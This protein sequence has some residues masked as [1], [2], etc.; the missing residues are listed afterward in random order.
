MNCPIVE[1]FPT[2]LG[3]VPLDFFS[4]KETSAFMG[5]K[6]GDLFV[7]WES[8]DKFFVTEFGLFVDIPPMVSWPFAIDNGVEPMG[9]EVTFS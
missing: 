6:I 2:E 3:L 8:D 7:V 9:K 4:F 1:V 5:V